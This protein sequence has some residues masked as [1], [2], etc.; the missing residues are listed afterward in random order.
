MEFDDFIMITL[1]FGFLAWK[2]TELNCIILSQHITV[3]GEIRA[4]QS[5]SAIQVTV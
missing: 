2:V 3:S 4:R 5:G 1:D